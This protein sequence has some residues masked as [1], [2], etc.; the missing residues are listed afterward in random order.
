MKLCKCG[1]GM[2]IEHPKQSGMP[3]LW[4]SGHQKKKRVPIGKKCQQCGKDITA[5]QFQ[6]KQALRV[7]SY[8]SVSCRA[9]WRAEHQDNQKATEAMRKVG[10]TPEVKAKRVES[11]RKSQK[12]RAV[13]ARLQLPEIREKARIT[14]SKMPGFQSLPEHYAAKT[15]RLRD[16][17]GRVHEFRNLCY[18]IRKHPELFH[19]EDL[20]PRGK[21]SHLGILSCRAYRGIKSIRPERFGK[22]NGQWKNWTWYSQNERVLNAGDDLLNRK[23]AA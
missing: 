21:K 3:R 11:L 16:H 9:L 15:W 12:F 13:V 1:C 22:I 17:N 5:T 2:I 20:T 19:E 14:K 4:I 10:L 6:V 23:V 8:C 7:R 18:F